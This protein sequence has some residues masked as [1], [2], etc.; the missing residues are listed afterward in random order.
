MRVICLND[1][2]GENFDSESLL[3]ISEP[4]VISIP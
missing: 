4:Y 2:S 3:H 1:F